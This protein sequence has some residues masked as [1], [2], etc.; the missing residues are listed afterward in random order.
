MNEQGL[1][2]WRVVVSNETTVRLLYVK[3]ATRENASALAK[4]DLE[5]GSGFPCVVQECGEVPPLPE[6]KVLT[7]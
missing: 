5:R 3:A 1:K 2:E 4:D 7:K 6:G